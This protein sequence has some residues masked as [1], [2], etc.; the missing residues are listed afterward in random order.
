[1]NLK[2][3][4]TAILLLVPPAVAF[5][6]GPGGV[7][8][9]EPLLSGIRQVT[10]VGERSGEAY[11]SPDGKSI[12]FQSVREGCPHYQIYTLEFDGPGQ[13][14]GL[15][16]VSPGKGLT[17]C[18]YFH[19]TKPRVLFASTHLDPAT[20]GPPPPAARGG[21]YAW[22]RH[23][24][25]D[26]FESDPDG[27]NLVRLTDTPGYDAECA[28]SPDG[29]RIVFC[30]ERDGDPEIYTMAADGTDVRRVT[31]TPGYDGG[32]F[33]SPDGKRICFRGFRDP[34]NERWAQVY[35]INADGT[36]EEQLTFNQAVNW[37]P[38]FHPGGEHLLYSTNVEGHSNYE[39]LLLRT[40]DRKVAW[41]T[42]D[43]RADVLPVFSP[44]GRRILWTSTRN[45]GISQIFV[46]DFRMPAEE[47]FFPPLEAAPAAPASRPTP[48]RESVS[49]EDIDANELLAHVQVLADDRYEGRR[50]GTP[51]AALAA[52][53]VEGMMQ[54]LGLAPA[55]ENGTY[56][57]GFDVPAGFEI[58]ASCTF[59]MGAEPWDI[60]RAWRPLS[61]SSDGAFGAPAVFVGYGITTPDGSYD[62]YKGIDVT[63]KVVIA[64]LRGVPRFEGQSAE[65]R[66]TLAG[67]GSARYKAFNAKRHGAAGVVF[68]T[69][70][71]QRFGDELEPL[72]G[73]GQSSRVGIPAIQVRRSLFLERFPD[74]AAH[75][76]EAEKAAD[77]G[78]TLS[79][80]FPEIT[81]ATHVSIR[82]LRARADNVV[83]RVPGTDPARADRILVIGAHYDHLGRGGPGSLAGT[84][85]IHNGADDNA[86][87]TAG[88]LE[89]AEHFARKPIAN[90]VLFIAFAGEEEGLL[91]SAR[92]C[93][94]PTVPAG[95]VE[96]MVNLDMVGRLGDSGIA[97]DGVASSP[98]WPSVIE[99]ANTGGLR[100]ALTAGQFGGRSDH[101]S[102]I[103]AGVPAVHAFTGAHADYHRPSDDWDRI[104]GPGMADTVR[105][106]AR[107][108]RLV[109]GEAARMPFEKAPA[110]GPHGGT[111]T[112]A[113]AG[114]GAWFGSRPD[115][116]SERGGVKIAGTSPGSPAE[117]AGVRPG[118]ILVGFGDVDVDNIMDFTFALRSYRPGDRVEVRILRDGKP[119]RLSAVLERN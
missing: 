19:P 6:Q 94:S 84:D 53:Y 80:E 66:A 110:A 8:V 69:D 116:G 18:S 76:A 101:V 95:S 59:S 67:L 22:N 82:E 119:V 92:F 118:D 38:Y 33:F 74:V 75:M 48:P 62:D 16:R 14:S 54:K 93:A 71:R 104:N 65:A 50:T 2:V 96:A 112:R 52:D 97:V 42:R 25:F 115:Y 90:P 39:I 87:G 3:A 99:A 12:I 35:V 68:V 79:K 60:D 10:F 29:S 56:R 47:D 83:G 5:P 28:Y 7:A 51:G 72:A 11:F 103:S 89:L 43:P 57:Q 106:V 32:P 30:S 49:T 73:D 27:G 64:W 86:S 85:E 24:S 13:E 4:V 21:R 58:D 26:V 70:G 46:A 41:V 23:P 55:G 108:V 78:R 102:F 31:R 81:A 20:F 61:F 34:T 37:A 111:T 113:S 15:R 91:G 9:A 114:Y 105:F 44:D 17:T 88:L 1:M 98:R 107:V 77:G 40:R 109:A 100:I 117:K 63:Y 36:G 45:G